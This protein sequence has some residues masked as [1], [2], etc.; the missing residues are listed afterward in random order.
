MDLSFPE[1]LDRQILGDRLRVIREKTFRLSQEDFGA[2][3]GVNKGTIG[4][5]ERGESRVPLDVVCRI[6]W[7]L[8]IP[9]DY[10]VRPEDEE[11]CWLLDRKQIKILRSGRA[12]AKTRRR[13]WFRE[14][15]ASSY[16]VRDP[17]EMAR[18]EEELRP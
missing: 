8:Q 3:L 2:A 13:P 5:W 17:V 6:A 10:L 18:M 1:P 11:P 9:I 14:I 4:A 7:K 16:V 15:N 12:D